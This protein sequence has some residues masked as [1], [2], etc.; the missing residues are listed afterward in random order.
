MKHSDGS[1]FFSTFLPAVLGAG[2][3][4]PGYPLVVWSLPQ[5]QAWVPRRM[6]SPGL[7]LSP[8]RCS[9]TPTSWKWAPSW[10]CSAGP[11]PQ[12]CSPDFTTRRTWPGPSS[13]AR[14]GLRGVGRGVLWA[15]WLRVLGQTFRTHFSMV[16]LTGSAL[17]PK[18]FQGLLL[19]AAYGAPSSLGSHF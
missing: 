8:T 10:T 18:L 11:L 5:L 2:G 4:L 9:W 14:V 7:A 6:A 12:A 17:L 13:L 15:G 3:T 16:P 1:P 19:S